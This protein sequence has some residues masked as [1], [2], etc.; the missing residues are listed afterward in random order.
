M[1]TLQEE[2]IGQQVTSYLNTQHIGA[3]VFTDSHFLE[4]SPLAFTFHFLLNWDKQ[5]VKYL[6]NELDQSLFISNLYNRNFPILFSK[7]PISLITIEKKLTNYTQ[8]ISGLCTQEKNIALQITSPKLL[9]LVDQDIDLSVENSIANFKV[10]LKHP[11]FEHA[12]T[13]SADLYRWKNP[14]P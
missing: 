6:H 5:F 8:L 11:H 10:A 13:L 9:I 3:C 14:L 1:N 7:K 12:S 2:L 4:K